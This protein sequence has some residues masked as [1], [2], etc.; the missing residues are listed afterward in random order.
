MDRST[1]T[2][3][4]IDE[5]ERMLDALQRTL[6]EPPAGHHWLALETE[7]T[8]DGWVVAYRSQAEFPDEV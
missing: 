1:V 6:G 8:T 2:L 5:S 3:T 7:E 4:R